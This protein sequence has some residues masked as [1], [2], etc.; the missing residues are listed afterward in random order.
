MLLFNRPRHYLGL[1]G[2]Y[3]YYYYY[4]FRFFCS[5]NLVILE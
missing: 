3:Y 1:S 4:Y 5:I 2:S